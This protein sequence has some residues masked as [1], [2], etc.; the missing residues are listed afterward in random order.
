MRWLLLRIAACSGV[1]LT[2]ALAQA[3]KP[4]LVQILNN[5]SV[6]GKDFPA[7]LRGLPAW[8]AQ[9]EQEV[10]VFAHRAV[11]A[12]ALDTKEESEKRAAQLNDMLLKLQV[13]F[14][15][16][17]RSLAEAPTGRLRAEAIAFPEDDSQRV[18]V[19]DSSL[20]LL[21]PELTPAR[22]REALGPAERV[23]Y[24]TVQNKFERRPIQLTVYEYADGQIG[25]A[26][27]NPSLRPGFID[28]VLLKVRAVN[29]AV[30]EE[31][32]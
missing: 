7:V 17:F 9:G 3:S 14:K 6:F 15:P 24:V 5:R 29:A 31:A 2:V 10:V 11:G 23:A 26:E 21:N 25:F 13:Q 18:A 32:R 20:Q 19:S 27:P 12:T 16:D 1:I 30:F 8:N 28:R 22:L 4:T